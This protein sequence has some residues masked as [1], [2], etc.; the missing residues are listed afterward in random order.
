MAGMRSLSSSL[1]DPAGFRLSPGRP[2]PLGVTPDA[3]GANV[4]VFSAGA[5]RIDLC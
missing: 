1:P 4:A 3:E 5:S 2:F